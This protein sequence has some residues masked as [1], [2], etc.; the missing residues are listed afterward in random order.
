MS[1][2]SRAVKFAVKFA[3]IG[4]PG[5]NCML[6]VLDLARFLLSPKKNIPNSNETKKPRMNSHASRGWAPALAQFL[7][8]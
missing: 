3:S 7:L 8:I 2:Q 4:L 6:S 5:F 1:L